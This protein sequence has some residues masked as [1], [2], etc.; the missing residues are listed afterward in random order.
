MATVNFLLVGAGGS[1]GSA[2]GG[3]GAAGEVITGSDTITSGTFPVVVG[4]GGVGVGF[5]NPGNAGSSAS[6]W[7]AHSAGAGGAG[8][9]GNNVAGGSNASYSGGAGGGFSTADC[10]GGAGSAGN[11]GASSGDTGGDGGPGTTSSISGASVTYGRGG[12]GCGYFVAGAPNGA[13]D[14]SPSGASDGVNPGDGGGG[15]N[16]FSNSGAGKDGLVILSYPTGSLT[17]FGGVISTSGGNTIHTFTPFSDNTFRVTT[18]YTINA[19]AGS[20]GLTGFLE[21]QQFS[22][23]YTAGSYSISGAASTFNLLLA[24]NNL[25]AF[26]GDYA[27]TGADVGLYLTR[28]MNAVAGSYAIT[29]APVTFRLFISPFAPASQ[30]LWLLE[31]FDIRPRTEQSS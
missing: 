25:A 8:P 18:T 5:G 23:A 31:R 3:G 29:G 6:T 19:E 26:P 28:L 12:G 4:T 10:G 9:A 7:N 30:P 16:R 13:N 1:G 22:K 15:A 14:F 20:Y 17:A 21:R 11:G 24:G 2:F 27:I